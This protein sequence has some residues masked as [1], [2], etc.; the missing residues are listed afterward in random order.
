MTGYLSAPEQDVVRTV[1]RTLPSPTRATVAAR[2]TE[3][4]GRPVGPD[5][6]R[7]YR[8]GDLHSRAGVA[9]PRPEPAR[10]RPSLPY[11]SPLADLILE[12]R[13]VRRRLGLGRREV[14][15]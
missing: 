4:L 15:T 13:A 10:P 2:A 12:A 3:L 14:A 8:P 11:P 5:A 7:R 1:W 6:A 9:M